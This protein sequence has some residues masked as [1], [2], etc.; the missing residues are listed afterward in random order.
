MAVTP[1]SET[2][3]ITV[4]QGLEPEVNVDHCWEIFGNPMPADVNSPVAVSSLV[5]LPVSCE[6]STW[7]TG[8]WGNYVSA[9]R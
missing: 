7:K 5:A 2:D 9:P 4:T 1:I 8:T 3:F 6:D